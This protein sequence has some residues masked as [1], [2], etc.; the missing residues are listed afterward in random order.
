MYIDIVPNRDSPPAILLR[1]THREGGKIV[2]STIANLSKCPPEAIEALRLSSPGGKTDPSREQRLLHRAFDPTRAR[3]GRFGD[4]ESTG[5]G[6]PV[7][8]A[9]LPRTGPRIGHDRPTNSPSLFQV[10]YNSAVE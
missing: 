6:Y 5:D 2:K 9:S 1:E 3:P 10:G 8:V 4:D 7:G